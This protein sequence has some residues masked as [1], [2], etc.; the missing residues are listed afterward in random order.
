[1]R[2]LSLLSV[3][4]AAMLLVSGLAG[5][6]QAH[7]GVH[8][9]RAEGAGAV[10]M[11]VS[12]DEDQSPCHCHGGTVCVQ[13]IEA[14]QSLLRIFEQPMRAATMPFGPRHERSLF[15]PADPPPPRA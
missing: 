9:L 14:S 6:A 15:F 13:V 8:E 10:V 3:A 1:M 11:D 12:A 2:L 4:L 5:A 7:G